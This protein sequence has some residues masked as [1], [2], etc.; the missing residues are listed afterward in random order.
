MPSEDFTLSTEPLYNFFAPLDSI[1]REFLLDKNDLR[2]N[3]Y[4]YLLNA[5]VAIYDA[6]HPHML[7]VDCDSGSNS[8][9]G[10]TKSNAKRDVQ[11]AVDTIAAMPDDEEVKGGEI[12]LLPGRLHTKFEIDKP[13]IKVKGTGG[14]GQ[15]SIV[16]LG[17]TCVKVLNGQVGAKLGMNLPAH[18][19]PGEVFAAGEL[20]DIHFYADSVGTPAA[21]IQYGRFSNFINR[22]CAASGFSAG[23]G[24]DVVGSDSSQYGTIIDPILS[25]NEINLHVQDHNDIHIA[26]GFIQ[27]LVDEPEVVAGTYGIKGETGAEVTA[28]GTRMQFLDK[29]F[30]VAGENSGVAFCRFEAFNVGVTLRGAKQ[31]VGPWCRFNNNIIKI[32]EDEFVGR[33]IYV[34][35]TAED[36]KISPFI[37]GAMAPRQVLD[38]GARTWR[39][40]A[41]PV[42]VN[43]PSSIAAD[44]Q[45]PLFSIPEDFPYANVLIE[46]CQLNVGLQAI[47]LSEANYW[48]LTVLHDNTPLSGTT[49]AKNSQAGWAARQMVPFSPIVSDNVLHPGAVIYVQ[50]IKSGAPAALVA[51]SM[52]FLLV[53][54]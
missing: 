34:T 1:D 12:V 50:A 22:R 39:G 42:H 28:V 18:P 11:A 51:G 47:A 2:I 46:K 37:Y 45:L 53:P 8:S 30:D 10:K 40:D 20:E 19:L 54:Y 23:K 24:I 26:R 4:K 38:E 16:G 17:S 13:N 36:A 29:P 33:S 49:C 7:Y 21:A 3:I 9:N 35:D 52:S 32:D 25:L 6:G 44:I 31:Y 27:N 48:T 5:D 15:D 14:I 41:Y 43:F